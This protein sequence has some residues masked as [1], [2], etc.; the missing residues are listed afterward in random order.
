MRKNNKNVV[1]VVERII[2]MWRWE[3]IEMLWW[4]WRR[5]TIEMWWWK[6]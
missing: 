6:K 1:E 5:K 3:T 4:W 2:E